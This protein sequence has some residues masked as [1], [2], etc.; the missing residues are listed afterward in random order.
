MD[1]FSGASQADLVVALSGGVDSCVLL[2][3]CH[4][5][6]PER[7]RAL[8]INH[9]YAAESASW[10]AHCQSLCDRLGVPLQSVELQPRAVKPALEF[11][12][13]AAREARYRV[14]SEQ[15]GSGQLL[16][17]AH[18]RD[19]QAESVLLHLLQGRGVFGMPQNRAFGDGWLL[20][21]LLGASREE[22]G[23]FARSRSI[24]W[25]DDPSN[26]DTDHDRNYLRHEI[27]PLLARRFA[28][29][30]PRLNQAAGHLAEVES[31]LI[32]Q[33]GLA[34]P[35]LA[36]ELL[37]GFSASQQQAVIRLWLS[38]NDIG[39]PS[40]RALAG[41][42]SQLAKPGDRQ[43]ALQVPGGRLRRYRGHLC[44]APALNVE[45]EPREIADHSA[46]AVRQGRLLI[47]HETPGLE[48]VGAPR[49]R[50]WQASD[51][52]GLPRTL[53]V[54]GHHRRIRELLR[55]AAVPPWRREGYPM[56]CD[57]QGVLCLP[58]IADR[59]GARSPAEGLQFRWLPALR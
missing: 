18:H 50:F 7:T 6:A 58:E 47:L 23:R 27:V 34:A 20:R 41:L 36:L 24:A 42:L 3:L 16:L 9:G 5:Y 51:Q 4:D 52:I 38:E 49:L 21:P 43:P 59:D 8:H 54:R 19:D 28:P 12:E 53:L 17:L 1:A 2:A 32:E 31:I 45:T 44:F 56:I 35:E 55:Q 57:D 14:F 48:P 15:I 39:Q 11:R 13:G 10:Q 37:A 30:A 22:I 26:Q 25:L 33:L 46:I 40:D 29:L